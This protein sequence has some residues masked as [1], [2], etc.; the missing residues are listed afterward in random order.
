M[1]DLFHTY[2]ITKALNQCIF[3]L[4]I[5][6]IGQCSEERFSHRNFAISKENEHGSVIPLLIIQSK[7]FLLQ[8]VWE[9]TLK[10]LSQFITFTGYHGTIQLCYFRSVN[11]KP[12]PCLH[13]RQEVH[14]ISIHISMLFT[15]YFTIIG[16]ASPSLP[17]IYHCLRLPQFIW[18]TVCHDAVKL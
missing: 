12:K 10:E 7:Q 1:H 15:I 13:D 2:L 3:L 9:Y 14:R 4:K 6:N 16:R 17:S 18:Y 5:G 8:R 11:G